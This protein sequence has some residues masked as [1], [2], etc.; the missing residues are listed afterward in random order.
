SVG[1]EVQ[2]YHRLHGGEN[3]PADA[4]ALWNLFRDALD[5][6]HESEQ[7]ERRL[8]TPSDMPEQKESRSHK[9]SAEHLL[10]TEVTCS[11]PLLTEEPISDKNSSREILNI[12][13]DEED[14]EE[15][16]KQS[17]IQISEGKAPR[18]A[19]FNYYNEEYD[20]PPPSNPSYKKKT[21]KVGFLGAV[22][23]AH[24][25]GDSSFCFP[26]LMAVD[27][28]GEPEWKPL[29][30]KIVKE[31]RSAV[32]DL[33][34]TAPYALQLVE[35]IGAQWLTPFD[36]QQTARS[37]LTPGQY[38]L[39]KTEYEELAKAAIQSQLLKKTRDGNRYTMEQFLGTDDWVSPADQEIQIPKNGF[40]GLPPAQ[41]N[42]WGPQ[43]P[44]AGQR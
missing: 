36:W 6:N 10:D 11:A 18:R 9:E 17:L 15:E 42:N 19:G 8:R 20:P 1:K 35:N 44:F 32:K 38:L 34:P 27:G 12:N 29:P 37:C 16:Q 2:K 3:M 41:T 14:L 23:Q 40:G 21:E 22:A 5:P 30:F 25:V 33:G 26:A 7:L 13:D 43:N 4:F 28:D 24:E 31:L 39:W